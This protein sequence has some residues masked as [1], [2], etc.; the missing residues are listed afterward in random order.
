MSTAEALG[1]T[2]EH[3][4]V[5]VPK[6][7]SVRYGG[8]PVLNT[9]AC[10]PAAAVKRHA[11][12]FGRPTQAGQ[13]YRVIYLPDPAK[14]AVIPFVDAMR[15]LRMGEPERPEAFLSQP[16][17]AEKRRIKDLPKKFRE[18]AD[19]LGDKDDQIRVLMNMVGE[20]TSKLEK[21]SADLQSVSSRLSAFEKAATAKE[22]PTP[23]SLV[24]PPPTTPKGKPR[25]G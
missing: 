15:I 21:Q 13:C 2:Q 11:D 20:Q 22:P 8:G 1:Y 9:P 25:G 14:R 6:Q 16:P 23:E 19:R 24:A 12:K 17:D 3:A 10:E 18:I 7:V 4:K 5:E